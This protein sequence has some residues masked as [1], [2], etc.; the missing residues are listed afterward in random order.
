MAAGLLAFALGYALANQYQLTHDVV[1]RLAA[2]DPASAASAFAVLAAQAAGLLAAL[3]WLPR[4]WARL[5]LG[6]AGAS[7]LVNLGYSGLVRELLTAGTLAWIAAEARQAG[8]AAGEFGG[9]LLLAGA[10]TI[11]AVACFAAARALLLRSGLVPSGRRFLWVGAVL[12]LLPGLLIR[13][14][15]RWPE[16]AERNLYGLAWELATAAPPPRRGEVTLVPDSA[17]APRH[18]LWLIDESVAAGPFAR[19]V[20]PVLAKVPHSDFGTAAALGHCSAPAQVAL[21]SGVDVRRARKDMDLRRTPSIW[22][23][24]KRAGYRTMLIDGQTAGAPQNLLL[25]PEAALIDELR[26]MAGGIDTDLRIANALNEQMKTP[27]KSFT[28]VV[29]RGV[30]FQYRDHYPA[31]AI[32]ADSPVALQYDTALTWSKRDFFDALLAGVDRQQVAI[33][34]T[35]DHGQN[36]TPGALPHCSRAPVADEFRVP[37]L[38]F[39]PDALAA[40]YSGAPRAGHS[41]SQIFPATLSWMG[42]DRAAVEARYDRDLDAPTARYVWFGRGVIPT[43]DGGEVSV[44]AGSDF[45]GNA[46]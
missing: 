6:L 29:L 28:M 10:Q 36:L 41:T 8:N 27:G 34:Y 19:L 9:P 40:R 32:A 15:E 7:I 30:H 26:A 44:T 24:A 16:G 17:G 23:Y 25:A 4:R 12:L 2:R 14:L 1:Y 45:P 31:G 35:S 37:L 11:A 33:V 13:P 3:V 42:Y 43:G 20:A 21:R 22:G 18:I 38:A 39:L 5:L 46:E